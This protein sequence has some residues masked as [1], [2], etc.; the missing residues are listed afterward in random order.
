MINEFIFNSYNWCIMNV[1][2]KP[3]KSDLI[4]WIAYYKL[5][6]PTDQHSWNSY[7]RTY[8]IGKKEYTLC[9]TGL[10][11]IDLILERSY[12]QLLYFHQLQYIYNELFEIPTELENSD[13]MG[14][15]KANTKSSISQEF[16]ERIQTKYNLNNE[17]SY[18]LAI[19]FTRHLISALPSYAECVKEV[20]TIIDNNF[21][22]I[23]FK[24]EES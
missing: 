22:F 17:V 8:S 10:N 13:F 19:Q 18:K 14:Y 20:E 7:I 5:E 6:C 4:N 23:P 12:G 9:K 24:S 11:K 21:I 16:N 3:L 2:T 1:N 15:F